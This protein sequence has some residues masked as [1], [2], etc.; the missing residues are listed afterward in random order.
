MV[1]K[2][3]SEA[4]RHNHAWSLHKTIRILV[5]QCVSPVTPAVST[6]RGALYIVLLTTAFQ[7]AAV[8]LAAA[9]YDLHEHNKHRT[10]IR[11]S[12]KFKCTR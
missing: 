3:V 9:L 10:R 7:G 6:G 4:S 1:G 2:E 12:V 8:R 11:V 5:L